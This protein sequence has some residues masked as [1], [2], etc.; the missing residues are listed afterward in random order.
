MVFYLYYCPVCNHSFEIRKP[1]AKVGKSEE[2]PKC[3]I[4][5]VRKYTPISS[6]FGWRLSDESHERFHKDELVRDI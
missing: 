3:G 2:C 6:T 5:A 1:M 4:K